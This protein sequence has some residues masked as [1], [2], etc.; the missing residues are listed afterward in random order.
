MAKTK[1]QKKNYQS[2][3]EGRRKLEDDNLFSKYSNRFKRKKQVDGKWVDW[4]I[5]TDA[6]W[7]PEAAWNTIYQNVYGTE[8]PAADNK[9]LQAKELFDNYKSRGENDAYQQIR[10]QFSPK[11]VNEGERQID[12]K[13]NETTLQKEAE[14]R[15]LRQDSSFRID[16]ETINEGGD[17]EATDEVESLTDQALSKEGGSGDESGI[18][19]PPS[20]SDEV[21]QAT[22]KEK[23][24]GIQQAITDYYTAKGA[25]H[26]QKVLDKVGGQEYTTNFR[27]A[28]RNANKTQAWA[29]TID[30][31]PLEKS[32][33]FSKAEMDWGQY[34]AGDT[35][36]V[37]TRNQRRAYDEAVARS[38]LTEDQKV[39]MEETG[40]SASETKA[41][42]SDKGL[43]TVI[44]GMDTSK[45]SKSEGVSF[46]GG[47]KK[48][49]DE[50]LLS[51][52][53]KIRKR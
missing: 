43:E 31:A 28:F 49:D 37:M 52:I 35:L 4:D 45:A 5:R 3:R 38:K 30:S 40:R 25:A 46:E 12:V 41:I 7:N 51:R 22:L 21:S 10:R 14:L 32:N 19:E 44:G 29:D 9:Y 18:V 11:T 16:H 50:N 47:K 8:T 53:L 39:D 15:A 23:M 27:E 1:T 17:F 48:E 24:A 34:K 2:W 33:V 36:G 42:H 20:D 6:P 26:G 13:R